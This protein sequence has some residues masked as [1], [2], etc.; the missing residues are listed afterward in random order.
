[1]FQ[2]KTRCNQ[3][4]SLL[5]DTRFDNSDLTSRQ[6]VYVLKLKLPGK[7]QIGGWGGGGGLNVGSFLRTV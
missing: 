6:Y 1:M 4:R 5:I 3:Y 2:T 7:A